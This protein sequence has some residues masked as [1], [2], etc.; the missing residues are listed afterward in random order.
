MLIR[1]KIEMIKYHICPRL[2]RKDRRTVMYMDHNK[3][4]VR[5]NDLKVLNIILLKKVG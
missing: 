1:D 2:N 3:L 4:E 5:I